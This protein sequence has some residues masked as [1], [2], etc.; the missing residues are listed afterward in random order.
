MKIGAIRASSSMYGRISFA[1]NAQLIPTLSSGACE[2]EFHAAS[3][4]WPDSVRPEAS[5]I[6]SDAISPA[7]STAIVV[8]L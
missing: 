2:M 3:T 1:P 6:V 8:L 4:V 5:V 7:R